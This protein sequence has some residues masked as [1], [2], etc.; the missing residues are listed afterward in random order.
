MSEPLRIPTKIDEP[1]QFLLW[2]SDELIPIMTM[3]CFGVIMENIL[4]FMAIGYVFMRVYRRFKN[5]QPEGFLLHV[6]YWA[7][8]L[9]QKSRVMVNP[10]DRRWIP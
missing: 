9:P 5:R 8:F 7:G 3:M 2:S 4:F 6:L 10:F 1:V